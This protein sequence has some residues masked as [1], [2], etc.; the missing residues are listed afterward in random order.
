MDSFIKN[1]KEMKAPRW[2]S[3]KMLVTLAL[4]GAMV[5][6]FKGSLATILWQVTAL[7]GLWLLCT[8]LTDLADKHYNYKMKSDLLKELAKDGLTKEE[9]EVVEKVS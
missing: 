5:W 2:T 9:A 7:A 4:I 1:V 3:R 8:T 6:L